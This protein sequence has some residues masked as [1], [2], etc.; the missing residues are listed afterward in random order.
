MVDG[1]KLLPLPAGQQLSGDWSPA[2][3]AYLKGSLE[4][5]LPAGPPFV[6]PQFAWLGERYTGYPGVPDDLP[7]ADGLGWKVVEEA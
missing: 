6:L 4:L 7:L 2:N 3:P 5:T 1:V